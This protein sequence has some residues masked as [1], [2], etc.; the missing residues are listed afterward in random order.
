[1]ERGDGRMARRE[2]TARVEGVVARSAV[3]PLGPE[4]ARSAVGPLGPEPAR[5]AVGPLGRAAEDA[6]PFEAQMPGV[7]KTPSRA[8]EA[9]RLADRL[10]P[11][12]ALRPGGPSDD[13]GGPGDSPASVAWIRAERWRSEEARRPG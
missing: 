2:D 13:E 5:S 9:G 8:L 4:P 6:E 1:G 12:T 10:A 11:R 3:G 7:A